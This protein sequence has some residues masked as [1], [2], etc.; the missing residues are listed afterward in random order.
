MAQQSGNEPVPAA[1]EKRQA[2]TAKQQPASAKQ[3]PEEAGNEEK[4]NV[5]TAA[6]SSGATTVTPEVRLPGIPEALLRESRPPVDPSASARPK[7]AFAAAGDWNFQF[8]PY[9][10]MASIKGNAGIGD[11]V[12]EVDAKFTDI[13][14]EVNLGFMGAFEARRDRLVFL[15]DLIYLNLSDSTGTP[16]PLFSSVK[17]DF[18]AFILDPE[19]GYRLVDSENGSVDA[20][21]GI[22]YWHLRTRLEFRAGILP[23]TEANRSKNWVDVVGGLRG[24]ALLSERWFLTGKADVGGGGSNLT[25]QLFGGVGFNIGKNGAAVLGYRYLKVDYE[26]DGFLFDVS[27]K[28]PILGFNFR[29]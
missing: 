27:L 5:A 11:L 26:N 19:V 17:V 25:Y 22:R 12:A 6:D 29:F 23:D 21:V 9:L 28:G 7:P 3:Q 13:I 14:D 4:T 24:R 8:T 10:F 15:T 1:V 18:K 2:E 20:L 16:G